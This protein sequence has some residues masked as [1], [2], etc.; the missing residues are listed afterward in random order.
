MEAAMGLLLIAGVGVVMIVGL[1]RLLRETRRLSR[2]STGILLAVSHTLIV[3]GWLAVAPLYIAAERAENS[4]YGDVF[5]PYL[6]VPGAH[7]YHPASVWFGRVAFPWLLGRMDSFPASVI[8]VVVG[9]GLVGLLAGGVQWYLLG[10]GWDRVVGR[11]AL[12]EPPTAADG[13]GG[14]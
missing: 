3:C 6:L 9:P 12:P 7:I 1:A 2:R 4:P 11:R 14:S 5:V 8:C 13:G 10:A